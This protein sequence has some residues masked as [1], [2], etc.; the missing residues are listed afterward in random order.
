MESMNTIISI[1][2][3]VFLAFILLNTPLWL[4]TLGKWI[5]GKIY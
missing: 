1:L 3:C 2:G 5:W 4:Y